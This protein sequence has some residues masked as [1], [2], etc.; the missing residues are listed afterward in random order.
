MSF[1]I[2]PEA[3]IVSL[4]GLIE[5][6]TKVIALKKIAQI[7]ERLTRLENYKR[8]NEA[9]NDLIGQLVPLDQLFSGTSSGHQASPI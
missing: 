1:N 9:I 3:L 8:T 5:L 7:E 2:N 4:L 6:T